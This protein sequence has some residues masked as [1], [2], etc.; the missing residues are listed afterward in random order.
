MIKTV[1]INKCSNNYPKLWKSSFVRKIP[2]ILIIALICL[3]TSVTGANAAIAFGNLDIYVINEK[4]GYQ[5]GAKVELYT[6]NWVYIENKT[7]G[8]SGIV[9]WTDMKIGTYWYKVYY[10]SEFWGGGDTV[11]KTGVT[12]IKKF[13]R[14]TPYVVNVAIS[15]KNGIAKTT[16]APGENVTVNVTVKNPDLKNPYDTKVTLRIDQEKASPYTFEETH[17]PVYTSAGGYAY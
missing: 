13:Q 8:K 16:F 7:T 1:R 15:D 17:G 6:S 2:I 12:T 9:L 11:V 4:G 14:N 3:L 10:G 5:S